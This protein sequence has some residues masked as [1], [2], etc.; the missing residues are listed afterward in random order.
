MA[1]YIGPKYIGPTI[2]LGNWAYV[3]RKILWTQGIC[4]HKEPF[5]KNGAHFNEKAH[6]VS[7]M[8]ITIIEKL[9]I[10]KTKRENVYSI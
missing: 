1:N 7:D 3:E 8:E 9:F 4:E 10:Q 2:Y 6:S 5:K